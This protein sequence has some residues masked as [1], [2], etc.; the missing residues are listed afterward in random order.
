[1]VRLKFC[2]VCHKIKKIG[3]WTAIDDKIEKELRRKFGKWEADMVQCEVCADVEVPNGT[4]SE[5]P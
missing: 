5:V 4:P 2:V 1:M 3:K